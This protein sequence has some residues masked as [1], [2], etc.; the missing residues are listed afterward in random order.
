VYNDTALGSDGD[1]VYIT[2]CLG[3]KYDYQQ[4]MG[5]YFYDDTGSESEEEGQG[6]T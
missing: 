1:Q 5:G 3:D 6:D 2:D 4:I